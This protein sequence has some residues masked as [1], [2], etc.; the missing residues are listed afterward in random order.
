M[1]LTLKNEI[2]RALEN[3]NTLHFKEYKVGHYVV[4]QCICNEGTE[5]EYTIYDISK[6]R[7]I[8]YLPTVYAHFNLLNGEL[9]GFDVQ[10]TSYGALE[11]DEIEVFLKRMKEGVAVARALTAEFCKEVER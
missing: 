1:K 8:D 11:L 3:G 7:S 10:T 5:D 2:K 9:K 4:M 6:D